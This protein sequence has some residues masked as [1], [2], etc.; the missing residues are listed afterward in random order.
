MKKHWTV[1]AALGFV[2]VLAFSG[3]DSAMA[4]EATAPAAETS[5]ALTTARSVARPARR[6]RRRRATRRSVNNAQ[7][8]QGFPGATST[9]GITTS[10]GLNAKPA[11]TAAALPAGTLDLGTGLSFQLNYI[12][13]SAGNV[14]G[15][16]R[17][18]ADYADQILFGVDADLGKLI[19]VPGG[20]LHVI[21]TQR[22]GRSLSNDFIGNSL[23]PQEIYDGSENTR[24]TI[25]SYEQKF[26]ND[27]LD[28]EVGR[29]PAQ[30]AF[31][32]SPLYCDFQNV[33]VCGSPEIVFNDTGFTFFPTSTYGG[34]AKYFFN[35]KVF[36]HAGVFEVHPST[37]ERSD[38]GTNFGVRGAT[39]VIIPLEL[40]YTTT[41]AN[42]ALPRNYGI[43]ALIDESRYNDPATDVA[44]GNALTSGLPIQ[45]HFGRTLAYGR[46]DQ[47]V[48]RPDPT[49]P[50]GLQIFGVASGGTS[51]AQPQKYQLELGGVYTGPFASRPYD[52]VGFV[53]TD[54]KYSGLGLANVRAARAVQGLNSA[55]VSSDEILLEANYGFQLTPAIRLTPNL[56]YIINPDQNP[57][58]FRTTRIPNALVIG[59]KISVDLFTLAGLAK[60]PGSL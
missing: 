28:V 4:Q 44:G 31:L 22:D 10:Q 23:A 11:T 16:I 34:H 49:S 14:T 51:G 43:G 24:L 20:T 60:G 38:H 41:A 6:V 25:L 2:E 8:G 56:Q 9:E 53:V 12:S 58:P 48:Y 54:Q 21:G 50:V 27:R 18:G 39:G 1:L 26:L 45:S 33:G 37:E 19:H 35:D 57:E 29:L 40:G 59:G 5:P 32:V 46:F 52:T 30:G 55:D 3:V 42:D 17:Q 36:F 7:G 47:Y 13:E 15:G